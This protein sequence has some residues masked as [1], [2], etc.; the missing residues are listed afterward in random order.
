MVQT[1]ADIIIDM[2]AAGRGA[3][4]SLRWLADWLPDADRRML[5]ENDLARIN[6]YAGDA[7]QLQELLGTIAPLTRPVWFEAAV[8]AEHGT[9]MVLG[10]GAVPGP[11]G[12]LDIGFAS[13]APA[14]QRMIGPFGPARVTTTGMARP[15]GVTDE[16]W[17]ELRAT[18]GIVIRALLLDEAGKLS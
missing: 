2:G 3:P 7:N 15:T 12:S 9:E 18:A 14:R 17:R 8:I 6:A 5:D 11:N 4:S 16:A 1:V 13:Y 10:C